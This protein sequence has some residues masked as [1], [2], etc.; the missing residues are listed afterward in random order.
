MYEIRRVRRTETPH[1]AATKT[2]SVRVRTGRCG[3]PTSLREARA[4]RRRA[5]FRRAVY[6]CALFAPSVKKA[7][8]IGYSS[9][10]AYVLPK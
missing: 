3:V 10:S 9:R 7:L 8:I 2:V 6:Q 1:D 4:Q 5:A